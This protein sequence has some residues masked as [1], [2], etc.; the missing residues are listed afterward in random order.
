MEN[1]GS[2]ATKYSDG[3]DGSPGGDGGNGGNA[4]RGGDAGSGGTIRISVPKTD[5]HLL[6]LC[7]TAKYSG[8]TGGS[9]GKPGRGGQSFQC[10]LTLSSIY[11]QL[12]QQAVEERVGQAVVHTNGQKGK[13]TIKNITGIPVAAVALLGDLAMPAKG[14]RQARMG[15]MGSSTSKYRTA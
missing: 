4:G 10:Y 12:L 3:T 14:L 11:N 6:V 5:T 15:K 8:G 7:G 2:D 9:A 1:R 13:E